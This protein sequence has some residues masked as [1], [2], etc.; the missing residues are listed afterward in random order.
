MMEKT[1]RT[2]HQATRLFQLYCASTVDLERFISRIDPD[3]CVTDPNT[4]WPRPFTEE[5]FYRYLRGPVIEPE[6]R[7]NLVDR[8]LMKADSK[9][10]PDLREFVRN[11]L[12]NAET[13]NSVRADTGS[14]SPAPPHYSS[15]P[16]AGHRTNL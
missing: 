12:K 16:R 11:I 15:T 9:E 3:Y 5:E 2:D 10:L 13:S 8:V 1:E 6:V 7:Q 14:R 4:L